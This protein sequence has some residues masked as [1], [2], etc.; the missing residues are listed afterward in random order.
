LAGS[1]SL[2]ILANYNLPLNRAL[3]AYQTMSSKLLKVYFWIFIILYPVLFIFELSESEPLEITDYLDYVIGIV[4]L[5]GVFG[6]CYQK[7]I[8]NNAFWRIYL[9][10][11]VVWDSLIM[12]KELKGDPDLSDPIFILLM[13]IITLIVV[14]PGYIGL[15]LYSYKTVECKST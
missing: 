15:Y 8:F 1:A 13:A 7:R 3:G 11:V 12:F 9:P 4:V 14:V 10:L 6:Y 5:L 2:H